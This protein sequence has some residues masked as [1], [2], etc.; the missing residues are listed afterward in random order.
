MDDVAQ[1]QSGADG[2]KLVDVAD[3]NERG[4]GGQCREQVRHEGDVDHG[5]FVHDEE[6]ALKRVAGM[7][8]ATAVGGVFEEAV[9]GAGGQT[10]GVGQALGGAASGSAENALDALGAEDEE[11]RIDESGLANAGPA[12][13]DEDALGDRLLQGVALLRGKDFSGA[14]FAPGDSFFEIDG[15]IRGRLPGKGEEPFGD[16]DLGFL[17]IRQ[18]D[19]GF[20]LDFVFEKFLLFQHPRQRLFDKSLVDLE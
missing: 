17:E 6:V 5:G 8:F 13:D 4:V 19:G 3:E 10:G 14:L 16:V 1:D 2:R 9:N 7:E 11:D 18:E 12:G 20:T 15:G